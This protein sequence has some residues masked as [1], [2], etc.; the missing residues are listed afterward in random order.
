MNAIANGLISIA[1]LAA[2]A[3]QLTAASPTI[4]GVNCF[5]TIPDQIISPFSV[6]REISFVVNDSDPGQTLRISGTSSD[7]TIVPDSNIIF[8]NPV[9][10]SGS[11]AV[12]SVR[13]LAGLGTGTTTI[14]LN[15]ADDEN[16]PKTNHISFTLIIQ[17]DADWGQTNPQEITIRDRAAAVAYP[18]VINI[19]DYTGTIAKVTVNIIGF[20]HPFPDDVD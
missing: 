7:Q 18:S 12:R 17:F 11:P 3:L 10:T 14:T 6:T 16:P 19:R 4:A 1:L 5:G 15:V 9:A 8:D 20:S 2:S 13:V